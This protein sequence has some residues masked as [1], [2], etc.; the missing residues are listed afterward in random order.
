MPVWVSLVISNFAESVSG[1]DYELS[2]C[3]SIFCLPAFSKV[4]N[5]VNI[6]QP[7]Q[8]IKTNLSPSTS[9]FIFS[10]VCNMFRPDVLAIFRESYAATFQRRITHVDT[11]FVLFTIIKIIRIGL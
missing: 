11:S 2:G 3:Q 5:H 1:S 6:D 4:G 7:S 9:F 8:R 10:Y